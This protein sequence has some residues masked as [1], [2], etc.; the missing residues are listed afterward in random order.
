MNNVFNYVVKGF[1]AFANVMQTI[2]NSILFTALYIVG[3]GLT[4]LIVKI[5]RIKLSKK[6]ENGTNWHD[7]NFKKRT[8]EEYLRQI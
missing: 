3:L 2:V 6:P 4:F 5:F 7:L 8:I 1:K